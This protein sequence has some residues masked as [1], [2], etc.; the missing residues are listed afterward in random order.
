L[1]APA[2]NASVFPLD[3]LAT[4]LQRLLDLL[5]V[6]MVIIA[7]ELLRDTVLL[8]QRAIVLSLISAPLMLNAARANAPP[9]EQLPMVLLVRRAHSSA[10]PDRSVGKEN[11]PQSQQT[12]LSRAP[13]LLTALQWRIQ[14][15]N[16]RVYCLMAKLIALSMDQ[17]QL[18]PLPLPT[19]LQLSI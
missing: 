13:T 2:A 6:L 18:K 14:L 17:V 5:F 1:N 16:V 10:R 3:K 9:S 11:A 4:V 8:L 12:N 7:M 15:V 19:M